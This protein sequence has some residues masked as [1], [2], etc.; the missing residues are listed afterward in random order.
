[1]VAVKELV[2]KVLPVAFRQWL[3]QSSASSEADL[4]V[5]PVWSNILSQDA[6]SEIPATHPLRENYRTED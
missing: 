2:A 3:E 1:M 6:D 4:E 5:F